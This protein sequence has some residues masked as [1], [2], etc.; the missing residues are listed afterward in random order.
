MPAFLRE[1]VQTTLNQLR[2]ALDAGDIARARELV[3]WLAENLK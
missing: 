2:K 3:D 1:A